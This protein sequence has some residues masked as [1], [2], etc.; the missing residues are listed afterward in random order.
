MLD[1]VA[2]YYES[3][4]TTKA[5]QLAII[6]GVFCFLA[7]AAYVAYIVIKFYTTYAQNYGNV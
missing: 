5:N 6:L 3:D 7:I 2:D 1:K 4:S